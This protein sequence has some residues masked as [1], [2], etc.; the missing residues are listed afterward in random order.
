MDR[1]KASRYA[2]WFGKTPTR[3]LY[4]LVGLALLAIGGLRLASLLHV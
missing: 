3:I 2:E 1:G 4:V